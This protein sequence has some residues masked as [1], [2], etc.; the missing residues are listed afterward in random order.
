MQES[1]PRETWESWYRE[2]EDKFTSEQKKSWYGSVADHYN[3]VRPRYPQPLIS[4]VVELAHLPK[5]ANILEIGCGPGIATTAFAQFGFSLVC[6]E[7]SQSACAIARQNCAQYPNVEI[8]NA[9]F[10]EWE[11]DSKK[12][13]AVLAATSFH[14]VSPEIGFQKSASV[15]NHNGSLILLWNMTLQPQYEIYQLL[16][17][18]YQSQAPGL[19]RYEDRE[20]QN[21]QLK[22]FGDAVIGCGYFKDLVSEQLPCELTYSID[23][24]LALLSTYSPYIALDPQKRETLFES[25]KDVLEQNCDKTLQVSYLSAFHVA[26]KI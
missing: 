14:W 3:R 25:L 23:E 1:D 20:K 18:V 19:G 24:Y 5:G 16:D 22:R 7:P 2:V 4:R 17:R 9:T 15:L 6:L 10:E 13:D 11:P 21:D 12:F 26:Q 8:V